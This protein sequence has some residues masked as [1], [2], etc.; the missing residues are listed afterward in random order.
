M[1]PK[2]IHYCWFGGNV[3]PDSALK[4]IESWQK[5]CPDY[6]IKEWNEKNYDVNKIQYVKEAYQE[7]KYAFVTDVARLDIV[8]QEGGIYLDT[9]VEIVKSLDE[10]LVHEAYMGMETVG[11]VNT[12]LGFGAKKHNQQIKA[13]LELYTDAKF[14]DMMTCVTYTTNML[15]RLGLKKNNEVQEINGLVI[16]P[17]DYLCPLSF[18]TSNLDITENT[19]SIHHYDMSWKD[20]KDKFIRLK[21]VLR[22]WLGDKVYDSIKNKIG[23][24]RL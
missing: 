14:G 1:I 18:E 15:L 22:R 17:T 9:D 21:I 20:K 3:L 6:E 12:G 23:N 8:L 2:V 19:Y 10:L 4:C 13:N 16:L 5:F 24:M 7:K 11:R